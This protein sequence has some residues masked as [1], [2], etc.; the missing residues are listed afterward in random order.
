MDNIYLTK[1]LGTPPRS[2]KIV[3]K[4]DGLLRRFIPWITLKSEWRGMASLGFRINLFHLLNLVLLQKIE[5]DI[6]E[7]GSCSG[8]STVIMRKILVDNNADKQIYAFDSFQGLPEIK[9]SDQ[10]YKKGDMAASLEKFNNNFDKLGL[11]RPITVK[12][13]F[14]NTLHQNLPKKIAFVLLDAD[15]YES[16]LTALNAIY[17]R[18][19]KNSICLLGVYDDPF[20]NFNGTTRSTY[21]SPGVKKACDKFFSDKPESVNVLVS[22][23]YTSGYFIKL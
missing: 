15:L 23:N 6:I 19:S 17:K 13:W 1:Y 21:K 12:G 5:G 14:E 9:H 20:L 7:I 8:E 22:G 16:T 10:V 2:S 11:E 18:M 3:D 4:I